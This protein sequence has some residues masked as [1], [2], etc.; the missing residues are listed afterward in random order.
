MMA[1]SRLAGMRSP[2]RKSPACTSARSWSRSWTYRGTWLCGWRWTGSIGSPLAANYIRHWPA[3]RANLSPGLSLSG[4]LF[5]RMVADAPVGL[6]RRQL[7][8]TE[9]R[10]VTFIALVDLGHRQVF[11]LHDVFPRFHF[12]RGISIVGVQRTAT[13]VHPHAKLSRG[14]LIILKAEALPH[15]R[16]IHHMHDVRQP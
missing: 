5:R 9:L 10:Q 11:G 3:T 6:A 1:S 2:G 15:T 8:E 14:R 7:P 13:L 12:L 4:L 16:A